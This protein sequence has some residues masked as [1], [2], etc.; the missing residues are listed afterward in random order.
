MKNLCFQGILDDA[1]VEKML[2]PRCGLSE[3]ITRIHIKRNSRRTKNKDKNKDKNNHKN[4]GKRYVQQG[5][6]WNPLFQKNGK[7]GAPFFFFF[8]KFF[9]I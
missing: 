2:T 7:V 8:N 9:V 6:D 5:S 3:N 1:T 4:R